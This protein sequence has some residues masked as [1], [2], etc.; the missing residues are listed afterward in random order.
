MQNLSIIKSVKTGGSLFARS[1]QWY[2]NER[3]TQIS[4][5]MS[6][7]CIKHLIKKLPR[8]FMYNSKKHYDDIPIHNLKFK[9]G[10]VA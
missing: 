6:F 4:K 5:W 7:K 1:P 9:Y 3:C 2:F 8:Q 10:N